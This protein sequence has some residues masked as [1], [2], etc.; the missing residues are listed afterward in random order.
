MSDNVYDMAS[1]DAG[2]VVSTDDDKKRVARLA[3]TQVQL[4]QKVIDLEETLKKVKEE[5]RRV[6]EQDLPEA[7]DKIGMAEFKL[8]DG[9]KI[10]VSKFYNASIGDEHKPKA[11]AWLDDNGH[12]SII[13]TE[14]AVNFGKGD[15]ELARAFQEWAR[16]W[17][18]ASIDPELDQSVHWQTLRAFVKEQ[19]ESGAGLPF[20]LFGV[21]I[22]RKAKITFPKAK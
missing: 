12:G 10:A 7:M 18:G 6:A 13:K 20:D 8:T 22:G 19:V 21:Y 2:Q 4:E 15:L 9:T 11:F 1:E 14:V 17:N 3:M 5:L 16:G